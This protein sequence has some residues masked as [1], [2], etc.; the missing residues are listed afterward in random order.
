MRLDKPTGFMLL[1]LPCAFGLAYASYFTDVSFKKYLLFLYGSI[2]MRAAGCIVNDIID[3]DIDKQ[4]IRTKNRPIASG[5]ISVFNALILAI[6]LFIAGAIILFSLG[7]Y[8]IYIGIFSVPLVLLY[9]LMKR[10]FAYPQVF[11]G[12]TF[13][14]GVIISFLYVMPKL[15]VFISLLYVG[16]IFWT[17]GYDTIYGYQD[18]KCDEKIGVKSVSITLDQYSSVL[19][20][21]CYMLFLTI[22]IMIG[23]YRDA[24]LVYYLILIAVGSQM[25]WQVK[26]LNVLSSANCLSRFKSN[27]VLGIFIFSALLSVSI[28]LM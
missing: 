4:V 8:A 5:N 16:C 26:T 22:L 12:I 9:P 11:L 2:V 15:D 13:N 1:F 14:M 7:S 10:V 28:N 25:I 24:R 17:L 6:L 18:K 20:L 3:R 19:I 21:V 23:I 27:V